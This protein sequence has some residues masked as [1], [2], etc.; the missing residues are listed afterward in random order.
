MF[1]VSEER[2]E[3]R[4]TVRAF[5]GRHATDDDLRRLADDPAGYDEPVWQALSGSLGLT[6]LGIPASFGGVDGSLVDLQVVMEEMGRVL[7][8]V[9]YLSSVVLAAGALLAAG[10][11][12]DYLPEIAAGT[13]LATLAHVPG[14]LTAHRSGSCHVLHGEVSFVLDGAAAGLLLL[15]AADGLYAVRGADVTATPM[16]TL[17]HTRRQAVVTCVDTPAH[18]I[19]DAALVGPAVRRATVALA[20]EQVGCARRMLEMCVAYAGQRVQF[21]R[22]IGSYQAIK[23]KLADMLIATE[24]SASAA[25]GAGFAADADSPDAAELASVAAA[26]CAQSVSDIADETIQTHGGIGFTWEHPAHFFFKRAKS[27]MLLFG[28]PRSHRAA[29]SAALPA[30]P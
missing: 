21:G 9:P 11:G 12:P 2:E 7:L 3:L 13:T 27:S 1:E 17:D 22:V 26:F 18:R 6:G 19:G 23:H 28:T 16:S 30:A 4:A 8:G 25:Y 14:S 29:L 20:A 5:L 15:P 10:A 24:L